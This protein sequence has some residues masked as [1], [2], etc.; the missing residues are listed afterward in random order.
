M[1]NQLA[2]GNLSSN[3][4]NLSRADRTAKYKDLP[5]ANSCKKYFKNSCA[6]KSGTGSRMTIMWGMCKFARARAKPNPSQELKIASFKPRLTAFWRAY[7]NSLIVKLSVSL[8]L[9]RP[10]SPSV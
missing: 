8:I 3:P 1:G 9:I 7:L 10:V 6:T 4:C 2:A 5:S